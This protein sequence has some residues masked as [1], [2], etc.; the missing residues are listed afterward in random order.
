M[1]AFYRWVGFGGDFVIQT[2]PIN[3]H[4]S[5]PNNKI[6]TPTN[7]KHTNHFKTELNT[8]HRSVW[9]SGG[10]GGGGG[11]VRYL[12]GGGVLGFGLVGCESCGLVAAGSL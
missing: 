2:L 12:D 10:V 6:K 5:T 11:G 3:R 4:P 7:T 8:V 9:L 1:R